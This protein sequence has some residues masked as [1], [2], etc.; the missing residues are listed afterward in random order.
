MTSAPQ[1]ASSRTAVGPARAI[2]KSST[3]VRAS[4]ASGGGM[5]DAS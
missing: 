5:R 2:V 1:S 4:G 3:V